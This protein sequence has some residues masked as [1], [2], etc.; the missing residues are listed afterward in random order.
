MAE[1][2]ITIAA[3]EE[4]PVIVTVPTDMT[5]EMLQKVEDYASKVLMSEEE[6]LLEIS[7]LFCVGMLAR[8][9]LADIISGGLEGAGA[10]RKWAIEAMAVEEGAE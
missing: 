5:S 7:P 8:A 4:T 9:T 1:I 6:K 2:T 3:G 10:I